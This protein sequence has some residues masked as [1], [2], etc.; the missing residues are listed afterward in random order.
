MRTGTA[1]PAV[2]PV[3]AA[4]I[5]VGPDMAR[6]TLERLLDAVPVSRVLLIGVS[7]GVAD[8]LGIGAVMAPAVVIDRRSGARFVPDHPAGVEARGTLLTCE[9][10][11]VGEGT[12]TAYRDQGIDAVDMETAAVA[13]VCTERGVPWS[14]FRA[15]SD[16]LVDDLVDDTI[17]GLTRPD[18]STNLAAVARLVLRH[19][20]DVRRL[21]RLGARPT[22]PCGPSPARRWV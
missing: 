19:P 22:W 9:T 3:V 12:L 4:V 7:G 11:A 20:G 10:L 21:A 8:T 16:R 18:G 1:G 5:G 6:R 13:A 14:V 17:L 2:T 15:I